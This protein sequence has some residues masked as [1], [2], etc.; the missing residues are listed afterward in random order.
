[1]GIVIGVIVVAVLVGYP[2]L[3]MVMKRKSKNC[4]S[5]GYKYTADD[6]KS[7]RGEQRAAMNKSIV[8]VKLLCPNCGNKEEKCIEVDNSY[9]IEDGIIE[10]YKN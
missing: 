10:Y 8:Y 3:N 5:C 9:G 4:K 6:V 2:V 1:M 7:Y